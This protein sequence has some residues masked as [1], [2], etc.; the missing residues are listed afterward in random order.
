MWG[1]IL[2][3]VEFFGTSLSTILVV[4]IL[5]IG[6]FTGDISDRY[7][8]RSVGM[9]VSAAPAGT[10]VNR[11]LSVGTGSMVLVRPGA[12]AVL[13]RDGDSRGLT[14]T[15]VAGVVSLLLIVRTVS[16]KSVALR[17]MIATD[18]RTYDV[19]NDRV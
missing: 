3:L 8:L 2:F 17:A 15:S 1:N 16:E 19:N 5:D 10:T 14:P 6:V 18:R 13:C 9:P 12:N 11:A 4:S 7:S